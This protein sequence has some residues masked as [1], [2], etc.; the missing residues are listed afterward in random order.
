MSDSDSGYHS[1]GPSTAPSTAPPSDND[2]TK[3]S[4]S[5]SSPI[6]LTSRPERIRQKTRATSSRP[7][8]VPESEDDN[9]RRTKVRFHPSVMSPKTRASPSSKKERNHAYKATAARAGQHPSLALQGV[10]TVLG[11]SEGHAKFGT[12]TFQQTVSDLWEE[13]NSMRKERG[14]WDDTSRMSFINS[15]M[16]L[17]TDIRNNRDIAG[18][19]EAR[20]RKFIRLGIDGVIE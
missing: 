14:K 10:K 8:N 4:K 3:R 20:S 17:D 2:V 16:C 15:L 18:D 11:E 1:V 19:Y 7:T 9:P 5:K 6:E 12:E 13:A